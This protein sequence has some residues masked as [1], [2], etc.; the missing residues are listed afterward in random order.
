MEEHKS[1][2]APKR[3]TLGKSVRFKTGRIVTEDM[4]EEKVLKAL[5]DELALAEAPVLVKLSRVEQ[6]ERAIKALTGKY[7]ASTLRRYLAG[8]QHYR[9]WCDKAKRVPWTATTFID[10]MYV[11]EEEGMGAS[12]PLAVARA[13]GWFQELCQVPDEK[14]IMGDMAVDLVIKELVRKLESKAPP[15]KRA[16]RWMALLIGPM[17]ELVMD[18]RAPPGRRRAAWMKLIKVWGALRFSD[19]ANMRTKDIKVYDGKMAAMLRKTKTTGAG[20]R[21]REL[22]VFI[23]ECAYVYQKEWMVTGYDHEEEVGFRGSVCL[24]RGHLR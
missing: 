13:V 14:K 4:A 16:P 3:G 21:V 24:Q 2:P 10:Y 11:R 22:P 5:R 7:R 1:L 19:T 23:D 6:P 9:K 18:T 12:I 17:E 20:K 15:I 8:W